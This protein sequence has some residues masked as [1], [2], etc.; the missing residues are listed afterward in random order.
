MMSVMVED[1]EGKAI[2][3]TKGAP[4]EIFHQCSQFELDGKLSPMDPALMTGLKGICEPQRR[5]LPGSGGGQ[6]GVAG[7]ADLLKGRRTRPRA[8]RLRGVSRSAQLYRGKRIEALHKHGVAVKILT[9]DN[10]LISRKVCRDVG[11]SADPMLLGGDVEKMSDA[12]L[13]DAAE[14]TTLFARLSPAHKQRVIRVLRSK[15]TWSD[16]WATGSTMLPPCMPR[17]SASRWIRRPT[18]PRNRR[19]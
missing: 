18:S 11:L 12:E 3:L 7:E 13:A 5:W 15:G 8:Q 6:K 17:T 9:G 4:E 10:D 2:L 19:I 1:P 16:S 14:K